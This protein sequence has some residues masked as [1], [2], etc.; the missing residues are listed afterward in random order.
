MWGV[1]GRARRMISLF[2]FLGTAVVLAS[3]IGASEFR[4]FLKAG[5]V[6]FLFLEVK[7]SNKCVGLLKVMATL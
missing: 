1:G 3:E 4:L 2:D 7:D 6:P 5:G